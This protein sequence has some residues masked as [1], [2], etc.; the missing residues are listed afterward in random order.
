[1]LNSWQWTYL[2]QILSAAQSLDHLEL[3]LELELE[4]I[5]SHF[6]NEQVCVTELVGY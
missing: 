1:V 5:E 3:E 4:L 6:N 2:Y